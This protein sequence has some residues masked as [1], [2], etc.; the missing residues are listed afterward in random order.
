MPGRKIRDEKDALT[1]LEHCERS[2]LGFREWARHNGVDG[3]SL[4]CWRLA[5]AKRQQSVRLVELVTETEPVATPARYIVRTGGYE[6]E[7]GDDFDS[8]TLVRLLDVVA[9]C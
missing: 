1:C 8:S 9:S 4:H 7:V 3:R 6:V 2:E 5:L